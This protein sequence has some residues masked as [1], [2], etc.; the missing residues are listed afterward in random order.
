MKIWTRI[1]EQQL[2]SSSGE[3]MGGER[4][5]EGRLGWE[6]EEG[7]EERRSERNQTGE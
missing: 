5:G 1:F 6:G 2:C 3:V 7:K 4:A